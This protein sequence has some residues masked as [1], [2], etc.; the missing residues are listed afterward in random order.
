MI[1]FC[2]AA[3][4]KHHH[5]CV[6]FLWRISSQNVL[7]TQNFETDFW[8]HN[9]WDNHN[10]IW[11]YRISCACHDSFKT[12]RRRY[13]EWGNMQ[14]FWKQIWCQRLQNKTKMS[15]L[16]LEEAT[17]DFVAITHHVSIKLLCPDWNSS[18]TM[19]MI[20]QFFSWSEQSLRKKNIYECSIA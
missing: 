9:M 5:V 18:A 12:Q 2:F 13:L 17:D 14:E 19:Q 7:V 15:F 8:K 3:K 1:S 6:S 10:Q 20:F 11:N 4:H 16:E